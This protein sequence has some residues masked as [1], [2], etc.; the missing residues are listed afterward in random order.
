MTI[1]FNQDP[2]LCANSACDVWFKPLHPAQKYHTPRCKNDVNNEINRIKYNDNNPIES[3]VC[4]LDEC[5]VR[6]LPDRRDQRFH[7]E[8]CR[9][10]HNHNNQN[11]RRRQQRANI[12]AG[13]PTRKRKRHGDRNPYHRTATEYMRYDGPE[14]KMK[15]VTIPKTLTSK[16]DLS[17]EETLD[18]MFP[19]TDAELREM[20]AA[21]HA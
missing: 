1:T 21:D 20:D 3:R 18:L 12:A 10:R 7:C 6:F 2:R 14:R 8:K 17:W 13:V 16:E 15:L 5:G 4:F 9:T 19:H 11:D